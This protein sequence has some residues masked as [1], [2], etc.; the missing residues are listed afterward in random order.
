MAIFR[1]GSPAA[2]ADKYLVLRA[3]FFASF[4]AADA[5]ER[6]RIAAEARRFH[7]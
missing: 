2:D 7:L 4:L 6:K 1:L 3:S 5:Q